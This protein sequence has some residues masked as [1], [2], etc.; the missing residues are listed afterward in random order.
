M[1][2]KGFITN[3]APPENRE[4]RIERLVA[5][6]G[7]QP[8]QWDAKWL[9]FWGYHELEADRLAQ[10][11]MRAPGWEPRWM[12]EL[13]RRT[14]LAFGRS[15]SRY[16]PL[17]LFPELWRMWG[18]R[19]PAPDDIDGL[20]RLGEL[21][22]TFSQHNHAK[23]EDEE[24]NW[25]QYH[26]GSLS[27]LFWCIRDGLTAAHRQT[28]EFNVFQRV[29]REQS[30]RLADEEDEAEQRR[31]ELKQQERKNTFGRPR[32]TLTDAV[33]R[34][35]SALDCSTPHAYKIYR[36]G[37]A[38]HDHRIK[39]A[40][41]FCDDP[42]R[43]APA[44]WLPTFGGTKV[45]D[46]LSFRA[47]LESGTDQFE[48][49]VLSKALGALSREAARGYLPDNI[50]DVMELRRASV[51]TSGEALMLVWEGY[52]AWRDAQPSKRPYRPRR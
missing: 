14:N 52:L 41:A 25:G 47:Y 35:T 39:L 32:S 50:K 37:S 40:Q 18:D 36:D 24:E 30:S 34:I 33:D 6:S 17:K 46:P 26:Q 1:T 15:K 51:V 22:R 4:E 13:E 9:R 38:I 3:R 48:A 19:L 27:D 10:P 16:N 7:L 28:W 8:Y 45:R 43:N 5:K 21:T 49:S 29:E 2:H 11:G 42:N 23:F 20:T 12:N 31:V 44:K